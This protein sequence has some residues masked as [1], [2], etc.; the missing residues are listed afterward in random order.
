MF[1]SIRL[2]FAPLPI[3]PCCIPFSPFL[4][5]PVLGTK[6]LFFLRTPSSIPPSLR[7][8]SAYPSLESYATD[9]FSHRLCFL[10]CPFLLGVHFT[11]PVC[12]FCMFTRPCGNLLARVALPAQ[13]MSCVPTI[14]SPWTQW[15]ASWFS[16]VLYF[17]ASRSCLVGFFPPQMHRLFSMSHRNCFHVEQTFYSLRS[18][19]P[20]GQAASTPSSFFDLVSP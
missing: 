11:P 14:L 20:E 8:T 9:F 2:S 13:Q 19:R 5:R 6:F 10:P 3:W 15:I 4:R 1:S 7:R 12:F 18:P 17:H 16:A